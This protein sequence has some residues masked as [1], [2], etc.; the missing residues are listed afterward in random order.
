MSIMIIDYQ[1]LAYKTFAPSITPLFKPMMVDGVMKQINTTIPT[2]T[3]KSIWN[4]SGKGSIRCA[5]TLEGGA[6]SRESYFESLGVEYK[7][8]REKLSPQMR[9]GIDLAIQLM[10]DGGVSCYRSAGFESDDQIYTLVRAI[11]ESGYTEPVY[12]VT[13]DHD[14]LPLVDKQVSVYLRSTRTVSMGASP[15]LKGYFQVTPESWDD[16]TYLSTRYGKS[17]QNGYIVP[18]NSVMLFKMLR[19][20]ASDSIKGIKGYGAKKYNKVIQQMLDDDVSFETIFRYENDWDVLEK[21]LQHYFDEATLGEMKNIFNGI[22]LKLVRPVEEVNLPHLIDGG[23][24]QT[25][26]LRYG[27][28]ISEA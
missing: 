28:H 16:F 13:N 24:L 8:G 23:K 25:S 22:R 21:V 11:K 5:V 6:S 10:L 7:A 15:K 2:Y 14:M 1:H 4:Y 19:G 18:Y 20:D 12:I 17:G 9:K 3:I 27:I 26:L